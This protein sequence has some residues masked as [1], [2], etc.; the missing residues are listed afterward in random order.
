MYLGTRESRDSQTRGGGGVGRSIHMYAYGKRLF[1]PTLSSVPL[2]LGIPLY[3]MDMSRR[4]WTTL[5][6]SCIRASLLTRN[7]AVSPSSKIPCCESSLL[8]MY[9]FTLLTCL[10]LSMKLGLIEEILYESMAIAFVESL[11][12]RKRCLLGERG[13]QPLHA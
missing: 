9:L 5:A 10:F 11:L 12:Q 13:C 3:N 7:S 8:L 4:L 1:Y 2:L 6:N